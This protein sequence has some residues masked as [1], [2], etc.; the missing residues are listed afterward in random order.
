M[1]CDYDALFDKVGIA[2]LN[3][4]VEVTLEVLTDLPFCK[5][6]VARRVVEVKPTESGAT[7]LNSYK[8][9]ETPINAFE[10]MPRNC[11]T[12]GTFYAGVAGEVI[13]FMPYDS[14]EY[15]SGVL[16]FYV[17]NATANTLTVKLSNSKTFTDA[18]VYEV[19]L[20]TLKADS[21][22]FKPVI[23]DLS[24]APNSTDGNGWTASRAGVYIS[25]ST[26]ASMGISTINVFDS[27]SDFATS[28]I[29]KV[30]CLTELGGDIELEAAEET[31]MSSGYD[32]SSA[33]QYDRTITGNK[34][35]P[36]YWMLNAMMRKG[37][38]VQA[39]LPVTREFTVV[40]GGD[41]GTVILPDIDQDECGFIGAQ[42]AN[43]CE[44]AGTVA[45]AE[46]TRLVVPSAVDV[47]ETEFFILNNDDG[48][49]TMYFNKELVGKDVKVAYPKLVDVE[50]EVADPNYIGEKRV[51][52]VETVTNKTGDGRIDSQIVTVYDNVLV[53]T[54]PNTINE[55]ETSFSFTIRVQRGRD[56]H[57]F[58]RYRIVD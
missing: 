35:T 51:R 47:E 7:P 3:K 19:S 6:L 29:V 31:C 39:L 2:K 38:A 37:D 42:I 48:T 1:K 15:S 45:D 58:H 43:T 32:T 36:N 44:V 50:E 8:R 5:S 23:I 46:L 20:N 41:Y 9:S 28:T 54:F 56:G 52:Y 10:C 17:K 26:D 21:K 4:E 40:D 57:Y 13:Y 14:T 25:I 55:D 34:V 24:K 33:P 27:M 11:K 30:G 49:A 18:D 53:T 12:S 22:G 16:T